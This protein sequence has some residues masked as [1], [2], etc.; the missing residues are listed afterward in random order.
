MKKLIYL[1]VMTILVSGC[2]VAN[3]YLLRDNP[4][5]VA[6]AKRLVEDYLEGQKIR[7][8]STREASPVYGKGVME[9]YG[10][11]DYRFEYAMLD[12][13]VSTLVYR[14]QY[15]NKMGGIIWSSY[16]FWFSYDKT[17]L[18]DKYDGLRIKTIIDIDATRQKFRSM[19][20][21]L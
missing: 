12:T 10:V 11:K 1:F 3:P 6:P 4:N 15:T 14:V 13:D 9:F 2:A 20:P 8:E 16:G 18:P 21:L 17:L 5:L 7:G 19:F